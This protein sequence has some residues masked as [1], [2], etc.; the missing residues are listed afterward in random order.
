MRPRR[1][2]RL[3]H[4][5]CREWI[6]AANINVAFSCA[7]R[8][9]R[10]RHA[11]QN[12]ERIALHQNAI[13]ERARL[14]FVSVANHVVRAIRIALKVHGLP[15]FPG[16]KRRTPASEKFRFDDFVNH[17]LGTPFECLFQR[18]VAAHPAVIIE[19]GWMHLPHAAQ[20]AQ[21]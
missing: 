16:R 7:N 12:G 6:F 18:V 9:R 4:L 3:F 13:L 11:F 5:L 17:T 1:L 2:D 14:G 19:T 21:L 15:F 8:E 10:N 20:Q